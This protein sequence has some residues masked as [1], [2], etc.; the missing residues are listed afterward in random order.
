MV[1]KVSDTLR[2]EMIVTNLSG[3]TSQE[4][5]AKKAILADFFCLNESLALPPCEVIDPD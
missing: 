3:L 1:T 2:R 5:A 4:K